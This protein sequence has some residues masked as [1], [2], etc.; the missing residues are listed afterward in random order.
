MGCGASKKAKEA[1]PEAA[2]RAKASGGASAEN[3]AP[4]KKE[5]LALYISDERTQTGAQG[6]DSGQQQPAVQPKD[7]QREI[8]R[9]QESIDREPN[10]YKH[11]V[12][13]AKV[14]LESGGDGERA[15]ADLE[16]C[17]C[18]SVRVCVCMSGRA[19]MCVL[20]A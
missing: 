13:L 11:R 3:S 4:P 12:A 19:R 16:V 14:L 7:F 18:A 8:E 17:V 10:D 15:F 9:V 2:V 5:E 1:S 20:V 6:A